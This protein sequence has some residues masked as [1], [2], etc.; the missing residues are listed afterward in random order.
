MWREAEVEVLVAFTGKHVS[1]ACDRNSTVEELKATLTVL[2]GVAQ[3]NQIITVRGGA[4]QGEARV[5]ELLFEDGWYQGGKVS[6]QDL[7]KDVRMNQQHSGQEKDMSSGAKSETGI[8]DDLE[9]GHKDPNL[10]A[11]QLPCLYLYDRSL[12]KPSVDVKVMENMPRYLS[13]RL[14]ELEMKV[15][16]LCQRGALATEVIR[17]QHT[18][19]DDGMDRATSLKLVGNDVYEVGNAFLEYS[20]R[21][22]HETEVIAMAVDDGLSAVEPHYEFI[23]N[24]RDSFQ[25]VFSKQYDIHKDVLSTFEDDVSLLQRIA[26]H[27]QIATAEVKVLGDVIELEEYRGVY[28]DCKRSHDSLIIQVR[29]MEREYG[30]LKEDVE[31]LFLRTP[32]VEFEDMVGR[33]TEAEG[34]M[35]ECRAHVESLKMKVPKG[36]A[37]CIDECMEYVQ[38]IWGICVKMHLLAQHCLNAKNRMRMDAIDVMKTVS[39]E[40]SR[41]RAMKDAMAPFREAL[42]RQNRRISHLGI[43]KML[44]VA[45]KQCLAECIRRIAFKEKYASFAAELAERMGRFREKEENVR[46]EFYSQ[47]KD[48]IPENLLHEMGL[49]GFYAP[50]CHVS[51]PEDED[52]TLLPVSFDEVRNVQIPRHSYSFFKRQVKMQQDTTSSTSRSMQRN[53]TSSLLTLENAKLRAEFASYVALECRSA[54]LEQKSMSAGES[55]RRLPEAAVPSKDDVIASLEA[56]LK[57]KD[58]LI[59]SLLQ[60]H[61]VEAQNESE[62]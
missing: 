60:S 52:T 17:E 24:A 19:P 57:A 9:C 14:Q 2:T 42:H 18:G 37:L 25:R 32:S 26:L 27:P 16:M 5:L 7:A 56:A 36:D 3:E 39:S 29:E 43:V 22:L 13:E 53:D 49:Q 61:G 41:I 47:V 28:E 4:V 1:L 44:P 62:C 51:V 31:N 58:E 6:A 54:L 48:I 11:Q 8:L 23:C 21:M 30:M 34:E 20:Q 50:H 45:Y 55:P 46:Q 59:Q 33:I 40:Q 35:K 38:A 12:L 15:G 10:P